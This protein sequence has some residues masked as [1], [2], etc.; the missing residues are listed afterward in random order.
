MRILHVYR[1]A[2]EIITE[3]HVS[4]YSDVW[5]YGMTMW[6]IYSLGKE[7]WHGLDMADVSVTRAAMC[8]SHC[9]SATCGVQYVAAT[10]IFSYTHNSCTHPGTFI[11]VHKLC[12]TVTHPLHQLTPSSHSRCNMSWDKV[13]VLPDPHYVR[14]RSTRLWFSAGIQSPTCDQHSWKLERPSARS[15]GCLHV[16]YVVNWYLQ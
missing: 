1:S 6:E 16:L 14:R 11:N 3:G 12:N 10:Y 7:P 15:H 13:T 4:T 5:S 9:P 8:S 2:L